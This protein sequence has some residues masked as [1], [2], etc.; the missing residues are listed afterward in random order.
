FEILCAI[1]FA[2]CS[3][4]TLREPKV[5]IEADLGF[6]QR[7][8][9]LKT[10]RRLLSLDSLPGGVRIE[11]GYRFSAYDCSRT[12]ILLIDKAIS[13][14]DECHDSRRAILS[15]IRYDSHTLLVE[16]AEVVT[17]KWPCAACRMRVV[18]T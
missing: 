16:N 18:F 10:Q 14:D 13:I 1:F 15:R 3:F 2:S 7:R 4:A 8:K 17:M 5:G 12:K 11:P 6:T 9:G